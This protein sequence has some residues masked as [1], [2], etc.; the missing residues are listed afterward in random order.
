MVAAV[1]DFKDW[2]VSSSKVPTKVVRLFY[3]LTVGARPW[4]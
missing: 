3:L 2:D 1:P 4:Q